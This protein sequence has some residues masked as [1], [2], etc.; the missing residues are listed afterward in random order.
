MTVKTIKP[1]GGD[2]S[3]LTAWAA[4]LTPI[5]LAPQQADIY[6]FGSGGLNEDVPFNG[7][8]TTNTNRLILNVP[9]GER[10][11][12]TAHSGAYIWGAGGTVI[13]FGSGVT[14]I[15]ISWLEI[16]CT[17]SS[18]EALHWYPGAA[19]TFNEFLVDHCI[20]HDVSASAGGVITGSSLSNVN[21]IF[22]NTL[23]YTNAA[24]RVIDVRGANSVEASNCTWYTQGGDQTFLGDGNCTAK[25]NYAG[26]TSSHDMWALFGILGSNNATSDTDGTTI[27]TGG[28]NSIAGST[29]FTSV[30]SGSENFTTKTGF[31]TF[32]SAAVTLAAIIDDI[33]GT[34]RP[35]GAAPDIGIFE[36]IVSASL[37]AAQQKPILQAVNRAGTY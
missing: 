7:F 15:T 13:R 34:S 9:S 21:L 5:L 36:N 10:H 30:T 25:N 2:F 14:Y 33:I 6:N 29:A 26:G 3:T 18:F 28:I 31:T 35:Q 12:G 19:S 22:R 8:T 1:S 23:V 17:S 37:I 24:G 4:S 20:V 11:N 27:G 16:E 32:N